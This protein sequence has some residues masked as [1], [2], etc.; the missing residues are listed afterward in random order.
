MT[1][2]HFEVL[3]VDYFQQHVLMCLRLPDMSW[4]FK[5]R[6][7][8]RGSLSVSNQFNPCFIWVCARADRL[9][10]WMCES[11][12][13]GCYFRVVLLCCWEHLRRTPMFF[14]RWKHTNVSLSI[15]PL[16]FGCQKGWPRGPELDPCI[17]DVSECSRVSQGGSCRIR[18]K[19]SQVESLLVALWMAETCWNMILIYW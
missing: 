10:N 3:K 12:T 11:E 15:V 6:V 4:C 2:V 13:A 7:N 16:H 9:G 17:Y 5:W 19:A 14:W 18:C 8:I 1:L